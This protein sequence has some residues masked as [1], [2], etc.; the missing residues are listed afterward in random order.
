M[1]TKSLKNKLGQ[2]TAEYLIM[3]ILVAVGA[4]GIFNLFGDTVRNQMTNVVCAFTGAGD[5]NCVSTATELQE[6]ATEARKRADKGMDMGGIL[7]RLLCL[8]NDTNT[9]T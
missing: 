8:K 4:I 7:L 5:D 6:S 3:L 2:N 1:S 9:L